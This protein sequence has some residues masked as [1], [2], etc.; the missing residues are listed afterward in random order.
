MA[1]QSRQGQ[2]SLA[3]QALSAVVTVNVLA[4]FTVLR[5]GGAGVPLPS[6][7]A[8]TSVLTPS[9]ELGISGTFKISCAVSRPSI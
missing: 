7:S 2:P 4:V 6:L 9:H 3:S 1:E 8:V 5:W